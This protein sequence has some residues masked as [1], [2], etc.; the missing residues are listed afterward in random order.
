LRGHEGEITSVTFAPDG[1]RVASGSIDGTVRIWNAITGDMIIPP[2]GGQGYAIYSVAFSPDGTKIASVSE[3]DTIHVWEVMSGVQL[4]KLRAESVRSS[5]VFSPDGKRIVAGSWKG[6]VLVWDLTTG[7]QEFP[8]L[9]HDSAVNSVFFSPDASRII[10]LACL[11][12]KSWDATSGDRIHLTEHS[13]H[14]FSGSMYITY[15]GWIVDSATDRTLGRLPAVVNHTCHAVHER[16]MAMG[17][18]NGRVFILNFPPALL[19]G[20]DTHPVEGK[21][22]KRF[23]RW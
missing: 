15:D 4:L 1:P 8:T 5:S 6:A 11:D 16:S 21:T 9:R 17:T 2:L 3:G 22:R 12:C 13:D 7:T 18:N 23:V 19:T 20:P 10:S 14:R